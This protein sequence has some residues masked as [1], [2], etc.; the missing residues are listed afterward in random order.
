MKQLQDYFAGQTWSGGSL[1]DNQRTDVSVAELGPLYLLSFYFSPSNSLRK[2]ED[3]EK[4]NKH[5]R[6]KINGMKASR[7]FWV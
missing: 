3:G 4:L 7:Q 1:L 5:L 6:D 2:R